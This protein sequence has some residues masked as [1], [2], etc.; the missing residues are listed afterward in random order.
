MGSLLYFLPGHTDGPHREMIE[1]AGLGYILDGHHTEGLSTR[2][3]YQGP[4]GQAG[5]VVSVV[6][7]GQKDEANSSIGYKPDRQTW[8]PP[9]RPGEAWLGIPK[10]KPTP[11]D[12]ERRTTING[13]PVRLE[14]GNDWVIPLARVWPE[15]TELPRI[16]FRSVNGELMGR[17]RSEYLGLATIAER[18]FY[19]IGS[20]N[21][22]E[23][24]DRK[25]ISLGVGP[26]EMWTA[27]C[28]ALEV[29]YRVSEREISALELMSTD[30]LPNVALALIDWPSIERYGAQKKTGRPG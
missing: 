25:R 2:A 21:P 20:S 7:Q 12:L 19:S 26:E 5:L 8:T 24:Q 10:D 4:D 28:R 23:V 1:N 6:P 9:V 3:C 14:D 11:R 27:A 29:N 13:H 17:I 22:G 15:G 18:I 16:V 30:C